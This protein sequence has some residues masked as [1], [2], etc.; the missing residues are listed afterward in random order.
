MLSLSSRQPQG[1]GAAVITSVFQLRKGGSEQCSDLPEASQLDVTDRESVSRAPQAPVATY[2]PSP[3]EKGLQGITES[4][5]WHPAN[6]LWGGAPQ[7][8]GEHGP[9]LQK[10]TQ[11]LGDGRLAHRGTLVWPKPPCGSYQEYSESRLD[12]NF[13]T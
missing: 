8:S 6:S 1:G 4:T 3:E 7:S 9:G 11:E 2:S 13:L 10:G 12:P 5:K